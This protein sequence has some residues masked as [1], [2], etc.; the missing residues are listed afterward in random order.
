MIESAAQCRGVILTLI[1]G[2]FRLT[3][4]LTHSICDTHAHIDSQHT[5]AVTLMNG[6]LLFTLP[7]LYL[8][9]APLVH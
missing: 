2:L 8:L 6:D 4:V 3:T 5:I 9:H 1:L 7:S